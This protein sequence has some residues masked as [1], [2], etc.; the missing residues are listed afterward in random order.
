MTD[1]LDK[2]QPKS[3]FPDANKTDWPNLHWQFRA[4]KA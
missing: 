2:S 4:K 3:S 1:H